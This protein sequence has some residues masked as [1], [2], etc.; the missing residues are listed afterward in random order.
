MKINLSKKTTLNLML[1]SVIISGGGTGGHIFPAIAIAQEIQRQFPSAK[2]L[3]IGAKGRMEMEKVPAFGYP[4]VGL[5]IAGIQR[6]WDWKNFLLPF[7]VVKS[8]WMARQEMKRFHPD[9]V[10]G[11]GGYASGPT[12]RMA[13]LMGIP[14]FIQEQNSFAG[15]TNKLLSKKANHIFVAYPEMGRFFDEKKIV[16]SGNPIRFQWDAQRYPSGVARDHFQL[17]PNK[18]T[19]LMIGGS[20][21]ARAM[22][23]AMDQ[24]LEEML[25]WDIQVI[26]QT[27]KNYIPQEKWKNHPRVWVGSFITEMHQAYAAADWIVS[28]AGAMSISE[29]SWVAKPTVFVPS[30]YVAEDH[31]THNAMALVN[32]GAALLIKEKN[33]KTEWLPLLQQL[34]KGEMDTSEMSRKMLHW[35]KPHAAHDIVKKIAQTLQP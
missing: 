33:I 30:P 32:D 2:I 34:V 27:G 18:K 26:W 3:F 22:N 1:N 11:V 4:I 25:Q 12:L 29:L 28:R 14:T 35:A 8:L 21:G 6:K 16:V 15:V 19:L 10:I 5:P 13:Q 17:D 20:L 7:K 9:A 31:Q 23:Q 24:F